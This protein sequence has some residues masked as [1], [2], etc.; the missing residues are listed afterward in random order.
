M[1][2]SFSVLCIA[3]WFDLR[4][5]F[6][7]LLNWMNF[8]DFSVYHNLALCFVIFL[9]KFVFCCSIV[10]WISL[11]PNRNYHAVM[12]ET[13]EA[14]W[15]YCEFC[16]LVVVACYWSVI[17]FIKIVNFYNIYSFCVVTF[18][19]MQINRDYTRSMI[20]FLFVGDEE[21]FLW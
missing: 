1:W 5:V 7:F 3:F 16:W 15:R 17:M 9:L 12:F 2:P 4:L 19:C 18:F 11:E 8:Q 10:Y 14:R 13:D 21:I 6:C 20:F